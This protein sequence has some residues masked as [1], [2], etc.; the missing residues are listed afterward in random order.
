MHTTRLTP[1]QEIS[2]LEHNNRALLDVLPDMILIIK[3]DFVIEHMNKVAVAKLG[4]K[5]GLKCH[6]VIFGRD[7]ACENDHCP[8]NNQQNPQNYGKMFEKKFN[9]N[10]YV[11]YCYA[12]FKG[13]LGDHLTLLIMR[14]VTEKKRHAIELENYNKNIEKILKE[15]IAILKENEAERQQLYQEVNF[16]KKE[17]D[18]FV[19]REKMIGESKS[20]HQLREKIHQ[21][22]ASDITI[23][24]TGESGT[25]KELVADLI[26]R[27]SSRA[28]QPY[29]KFN[30]A[31]VAE[32]LLESDLFGYEK[33]AFTGA[34]T[35]RKGKFEEV[36]G[37]TIFLDEIG[38]ISPKMQASLLRRAAAGRNPPAGLQQ[39]D[40]N[41]RAH[42]CRHQRRLKR[43]YAG[44]QIP[45]RPFLPVK[46]YQY[47]YCT[48]TGP[49][50]GYC[51]AC[52]EFSH[53]IQG[54]I[55]QRSD[56]SAQQRG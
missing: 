13:Y 34:T 51:S 52:H 43:R 2:R 1:K 22:A 6:E 20:I 7:T 17:T 11:E 42:Y 28:D 12:P 18:R 44:R 23:L 5:H 24:I 31:A 27:H 46:R 33:G 36:N 38:D 48:I 50:R 47:E 32:S 30:C 45:G 41:R 15:K 54:T 10:L 16:L 56:L 8:F 40:Q 39:T 25:G 26:H 9:D 37:G 21:V 49:Q 53:E 19:G 3:D 35:S 29:L 14:D 55:Q 4:K